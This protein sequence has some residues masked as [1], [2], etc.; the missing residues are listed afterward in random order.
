MAHE[1]TP[2]Q[3]L[4]VAEYLKDLNATQAAIRAGYSAHTA[5]EIAAEN[6]AKPSISATIA[7]KRAEQLKRVEIDSDFVLR[8]LM[9][10]ASADLSAAFD[11][12]GNLRP[13]HEIPEDTRKAISG[14]ECDE[15]YEGQGEERRWIGYT[16]KVKFWDKNKAL[17]NL[18][19]H[20]SLF[21]DKIEITADASLVDALRTARER[22]AIGTAADLI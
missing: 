13:I 12:H 11:E 9:K 6:L 3:Q 1:L 8:E 22:A 10:L 18:G 5:N 2:K 20:L 7:A 16:R 4:F 15:L 14:V 21:K 17:E 19:R